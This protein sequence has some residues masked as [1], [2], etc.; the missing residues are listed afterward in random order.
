M[1]GA[2]ASTA[3]PTRMCRACRR[4]L[5]KAQ[6]TRWVRQEGALV[7]DSAQRLPGRGSYSCSD[8]CAARLTDTT[9]RSKR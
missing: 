4:R 8:T 7:R 2:A 9:N 5:P 6:L 3:G 1:G